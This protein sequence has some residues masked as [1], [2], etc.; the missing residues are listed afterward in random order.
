MYRLIIPVAIL[1][2]VAQKSPYALPSCPSGMNY[3]IAE[4]STCSIPP[5]IKYTTIAFGLNDIWTYQEFENLSGGTLNVGC[6]NGVFGD[7]DPGS[8]KICCYTSNQNTGPSMGN[9]NWI[10]LCNENNYCKLPNNGVSYLVRFGYNTIWT[11]RYLEGGFSCNNDVFGDP[12]YG[13]DKEC[14]YIDESSNNVWISCGNENGGLCYLDGNNNVMRLVKYGYGSNYYYRQ[15]YSGD[16]YVPCNNNFFDDPSPGNDKFCYVS[17]ITSSNIFDGVI[18]QWSLI[19]S[20]GNCILEK[21]LQ[22]GTDSTSTNAKTNEWAMSLSTT[23]KE[24]ILFEGIE[25]TT[26]VSTTISETIEQ[27]YTVSVSTSCSVSCGSNSGAWYLYQWQLTGG[28]YVGMSLSNFNVYACNYWC[29]QNSSNAPKCPL[30]YCGD[31]SCST[32]SSNYT[33][34]SLTKKF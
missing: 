34:I 1:F 19:G 18:G 8:D 7:V 15:V 17:N 29:V 25:L 22:Y 32:C 21:S 5:S 20:C 9:T 4:G 16:H 26:E 33:S 24:G 3:C 2:F 14:W 30:G 12:Y 31:S 27:A 28:E 6:N 23:V 11:Y 10:K 13:S